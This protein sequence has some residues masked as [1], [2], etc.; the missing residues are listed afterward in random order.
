MLATFSGHDNLTALLMVL[1]C[2]ALA[3]HITR[4]FR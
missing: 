3:V 1:A 4:S 2:A